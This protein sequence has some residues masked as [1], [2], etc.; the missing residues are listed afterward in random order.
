[1]LPESLE[2]SMMLRRIIDYVLRQVY[3][4]QNFWEY[5]HRHLISIGMDIKYSTDLEVNENEITW[6]LKVHLPQELIDD[7]IRRMKRRQ[8]RFEKVHPLTKQK[9][10]RY[11]EESKIQEGEGYG[12]GTED[13]SA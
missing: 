7:L 8:L 13:L 4:V 9:E 12:E 2:E 1:M 3:Q 5:R 11:M 10:R 6:T